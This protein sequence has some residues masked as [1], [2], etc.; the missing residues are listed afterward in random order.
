MRV[1][2]EEAGAE[3]EAE[4]VPVRGPGDIREGGLGATA[5]GDVL[6][7][8]VLGAVGGHLAVVAARRKRAKGRSEV[9]EGGDL[10]EGAGHRR[11]GGSNLFEAFSTF[12]EIILCFRSGRVRKAARDVVVDEEGAKASKK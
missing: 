1:E 11:G 12:G 8:P 7:A 5:P 4:A 10:A 9:A 3:A 6:A 2:E